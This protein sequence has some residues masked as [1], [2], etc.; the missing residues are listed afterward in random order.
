MKLIQ[1]VIGHTVDRTFLNQR[2][3]FPLSRTITANQMDHENAVADDLDL[4]MAAIYGELHGKYV[5]RP[6]TRTLA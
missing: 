3:I 2:L 1:F 6:S 4:E 5:L